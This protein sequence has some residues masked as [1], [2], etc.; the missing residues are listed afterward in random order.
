[1]YNLVHTVLSKLIKNTLGTLFCKLVLEASIDG[2]VL[3]L[4]RG[5]KILRRLLYKNH[6]DL[7][8][9]SYDARR[10]PGTVAS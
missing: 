3:I 8:L 1:M 7:E 9:C 2:V 5:V 10:S 4:D 6:V